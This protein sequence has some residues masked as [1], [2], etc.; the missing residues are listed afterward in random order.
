MPESEYI[1]LIPKEELRRVRRLIQQVTD[2]RGGW[3]ATDVMMLDQ[4]WRQV[5]HDAQ[6]PVGGSWA[7]AV[8]LEDL[9]EGRL[10]ALSSVIDGVMLG[11]VLRKELNIRQSAQ[12][13]SASEGA[14]SSVVEKAVGSMTQGMLR[15]SIDDDDQGEADW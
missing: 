5:L 11:G 13:A 7:D 3:V 14:G 9:Q 4:A 1:Q 8:V 15:F 2:A 12:P 10:Q 6:K